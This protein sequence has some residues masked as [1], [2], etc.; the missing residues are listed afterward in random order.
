M[1]L[2]YSCFDRFINLIHSKETKK[3]Y[4]KYLNQFMRF[5]QF[6][7]YEQLLEIS[8]S[9]KFELISDFLI[10]LK[11]ERKV[12]PSSIN[13]TFSSIK[14]FYKSNRVSL[15][16]DHLTFF[17][18]KNTGKVIEDRIYTNKE[19]EQLMDHA[20][21]R[22]KVVILTLL[23]TRM[24]VGGLAGIRLK[25]M[26]YIEK[27]QLY[28]FKVYNDELAERYIT[29][30][31]PECASTIKKYL[32]WRESKGDSIKPESP[33]I[34]RKITRIDN[35]KD[36]KDKVVVINE[37]DKPIE[38]ESLQQ[39]TSRLQRKSN[40]IPKQ[41]ENDM[42]LRGRIRKPMMRCHSFR[43]IFNTI[44]IK[45]NMNHSVKEKLMGHKKNQ[46]LDFNYFRP[47]ETQLLEEY[48]K[49]VEALTINEES[50]LSKQI[51]E[52]QTNNEDK[53]Y[54]IKG[55][56]QEKDTEIK[57]MKEQINEMNKKF[58]QVFSIIQQNPLLANVKPGNLK[59]KL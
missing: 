27:Y 28:K 17:K 56:L 54:V 11:Q 15:D 12:S 36:S 35:R 59:N 22:M 39:A 31:T 10:Y 53:D 37:W 32:E 40:V 2:Q 7:K 42:Q 19:I 1:Q 38:S 52:L 47:S 8:D 24:R 43:K 49:V 34:Y 46:E 33:L 3:S 58:E 45:N 51:Q 29:F 25:D 44:C 26:E 5:C 14:R 21:L 6:E 4:T 20:D 23:S 41:S 50:K 48:L 55:K 13:I 30:C 9:K 16:W 18:G 57:G